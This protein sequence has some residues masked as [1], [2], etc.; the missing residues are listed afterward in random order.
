MAPVIKNINA[1]SA[2]LP[3]INT[4]PQLV[5]SAREQEKPAKSQLLIAHNV[6]EQP[7][8][9]QNVIQTEYPALIVMPQVN[10]HMKKK[11]PAQHVKGMVRKKKK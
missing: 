11:K 1:F 4:A 10:L 3:V 8:I 5:L 9:I 2:T 6:M 7:F